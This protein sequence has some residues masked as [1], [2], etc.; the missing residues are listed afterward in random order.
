MSGSRNSL[1]CWSVK[2]PIYPQLNWAILLYD[3]ILDG[4]K[5]SKLRSFNTQ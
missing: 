5:Q 3:F 4:K 1:I 2:R